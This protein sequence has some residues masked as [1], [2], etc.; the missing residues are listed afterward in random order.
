M[1]NIDD[2]NRVKEQYISS[3]AFHRTPGGR[4]GEITA[5]EQFE[6]RILES[7]D[8]VTQELYRLREPARIHTQHPQKFVP[9]QSLLQNR[10]E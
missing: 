10:S 4:V 3:Q 6:A 9:K 7:F 8:P 1:C 5:G 2:K